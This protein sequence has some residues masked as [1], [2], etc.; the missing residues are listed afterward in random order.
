MT[1]GTPA[2]RRPPTVITAAEVLAATRGRRLNG[3]MQARIDG[4]SI[5]SRRLRPG[6]LFIAIRGERFDGHAYVAAALE[7][8]AAGA[9]VMEPP[10]SLS[11]ALLGNRILLAAPDTTLALQAIARF[12]RRRSG[13]RVVGVTGSAGKTTTKEMTA[14]FLS[15]RYDVVRSGGN[16]NN[17]IGLPLSLLELRHGY[18]VGV[19]ELGMNHAGEISRLVAIAEPDVRVWTNV[20]E[21]HTEFFPSIEAIADAKAEVLHGA[22]PDTVLVANADDPRVMARVEGF[23]GR[24]VTFGQSPRASVRAEEVEDLGLEGTRARVVS[25]GGATR[26]ELPLPGLAHLLNSLAALA[27]GLVFEV[28]LDGMAAA[29]AR[30]APAAHRGEVHRLRNGIRVLDDSYNSNPRALEGALAV[31]ASDRVAGRKVAVLGEM[32]ELGERSVSLHE[33]CGRAAA[34]SG[35]SWLVTVGGEP[36]RAL[37]RAAIAAGLSPGQVEHAATSEEAA[38]KVVSGVEAGDLVLVKGSHGIGTDRV[39]ERLRAELA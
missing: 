3:D 18:E 31:L 27:V 34:A 17:H 19:V 28:P 22:T 38:G 10:A 1:A 4:F 9:I 12:I 15:L 39:V 5:D 25:A 2:H 36:A 35:V 21:V 7:A 32:L 23:P 30:L 14:A 8:G 37:G 24:V 11:P 13:A 33:R 20:A 16:L 6:D 26:W 29:A